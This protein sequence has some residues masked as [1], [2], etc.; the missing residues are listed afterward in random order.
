MSL[1]SGDPKDTK[2]SVSLGISK[3]WTKRASERTLTHIRVLRAKKLSLPFR[4]K[5]YA[6]ACEAAGSGVA[7]GGFGGTSIGFIDSSTS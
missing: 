5:R 7:G 1:F 2:I 3:F 4:S 6:I